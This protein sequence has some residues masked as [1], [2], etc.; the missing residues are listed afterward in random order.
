MF[1]SLIQPQTTLILFLISTDV[2]TQYKIFER[3]Y[4]HYN[5]SYI[6]LTAAC[7]S[8]LQNR[9]VIKMNVIGIILSHKRRQFINARPVLQ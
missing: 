5:G 3:Y 2:R 8:L 1:A 9:P 6:H 7:V 4:D